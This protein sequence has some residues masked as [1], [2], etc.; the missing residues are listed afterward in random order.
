MWLSQR[1]NNP[2]RCRSLP[3]CS[4]TCG[5]ACASAATGR[6]VCRIAAR[7]SRLVLLCIAAWVTDVTL[8]DAE[9]YVAWL[10]RLT[11]KTYRLLTEA[12]WKYAARAGSATAY[13]WGD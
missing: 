11:G 5:S 13:Y 4:L 9:G 8:A 12:E 6:C 2:A 7:S 3:I 1:R 10:S